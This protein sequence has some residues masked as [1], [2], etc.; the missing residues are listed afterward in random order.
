FTRNPF[1]GVH[2]RV[3]AKLTRL[4]GGD[5]LHS[6][7]AA[8][9]MGLPEEVAEAKESGK[10]LLQEWGEIKPVMPVASGGIHPALVP[11][12]IELLG[13]DLVINAG[14]G[15]HGHP[16]GTRAGATAMRQAI[17]ATMK[18]IP[19]EKYAETHPELKKAL[20]KW[21]YRYAEKSETLGRR[22]GE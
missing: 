1:H 11:K 19:L 14:G 3:I 9:K 16:D 10:V 8:G 13:T 5:Q 2:M 18:R 21:G 17:D 12:N 6:G 4:A 22:Y 20:D 15:I 7:T